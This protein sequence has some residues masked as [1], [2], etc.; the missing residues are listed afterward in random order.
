MIMPVNT[1]QSNL[2]NSANKYLPEGK[3]ETNLRTSIFYVNDFHGKSINI[4]R[5]IT[6]SRAFDH[7]VPSEKTDKLKLSSGDMQLGEPINANKVMIEAQNIM[8][9]MASAMGNH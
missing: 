4:E 1:F 3:T 6:A 7:F 9:I 2:I 5:T 8:G